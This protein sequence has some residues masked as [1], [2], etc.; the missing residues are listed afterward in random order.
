MPKLNCW[1]FKKCEKE[2]GGLKAEEYGVCP[3]A[4]NVKADGIHEGKNAGRCCWVVAGTLCNGEV[5]G[6]FAKKYNN[7]KECDFYKLV[8]EEESGNFQLSNI[9]LDKIK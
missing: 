3:A 7:C 2:P 5:Q 9:I 1:Q 4:T 6:T 8:K